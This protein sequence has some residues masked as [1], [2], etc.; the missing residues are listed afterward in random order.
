[1]TQKPYLKHLNVQEIT[2][3]LKEKAL[4]NYDKKAEEIDKMKFK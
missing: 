4:Q 1:M 2:D 3:E